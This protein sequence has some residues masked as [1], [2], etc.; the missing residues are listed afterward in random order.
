MTKF[1]IFVL[2]AV[3]KLLLMT[4]QCQHSAGID[5]QSTLSSLASITNQSRAITQQ[6]CA[7]LAVTSSF[8]VMET[9]LHQ[10]SI[11]QRCIVSNLSK[12]SCTIQHQPSTKSFV[13]WRHIAASVDLYNK[14]Q[15]CKHKCAH[16]KY[17]T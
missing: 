1:L 4:T 13:I 7:G 8:S 14:Q 9:T 11:F 16:K 3:L 10:H 6:S 15:Q 17:S 5:N 12:T 2:P